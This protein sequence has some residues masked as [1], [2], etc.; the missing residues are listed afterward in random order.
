M[1]KNNPIAGYL[2]LRQHEL[3]LKT[4]DELMCSGKVISYCSTSV[5]RRATI[6]RH[7][8]HLISKSFITMVSVNK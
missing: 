5:I 2:E 8:H 7:E 3:H 6:K 1:T 4:S